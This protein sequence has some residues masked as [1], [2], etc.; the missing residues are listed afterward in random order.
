MIRLQLIVLAQ[1]IASVQV[2]AVA[3]AVLILVPV[4]VR[5]PQV[6]AVA[7]PVAVL[8]PLVVAVA[9]LIVDAIAV[10]VLRPQLILRPKLI[11]LCAA[12]A[13]ARASATRATALRLRH[14]HRRTEQQRP[15]KGANQ[16]VFHEG[17]PFQPGLSNCNAG[18]NAVPPKIS[19]LAAFLLLGSA[20]FARSAQPVR[21]S[22][23][24]L[25]DELL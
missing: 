16:H 18:A 8:H 23:A 5:S 7:V 12:H 21:K 2:D 14:R 11:A 24:F 13:H 25:P 17:P 9:V 20:A 19:Q 1:L 10:L 15:G 4:L 3:I 6:V 22:C